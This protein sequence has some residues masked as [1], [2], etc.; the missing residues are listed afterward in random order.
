MAGELIAG[1]GLFKTMLD[2]AKGLKDM[3]DAAIRNGAVIDLQEKI[4]TAREAQT[5]LLERIGYLEK[6]VARFETWEAD[7]QRYALKD[8]GLGSLAYTVNESM[9]GSE[10]SH[11]ICAACYQ[12]GK[13][14]ILQPRDIGLDKMLVCPECKTQFKIGN[15]A[16]GSSV[17]V[18]SEY[19]PFA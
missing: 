18:K 16:L 8:V 17:N 15:I 14:S 11:Q 5:L 10:P 2:M 9:R 3:N 13:K 6:E 7:K 12:H 1:I 19:D 4:L